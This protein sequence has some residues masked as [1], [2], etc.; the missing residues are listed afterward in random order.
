MSDHG[1]HHHH[2]ADHHAEPKSKTSFRASFWFVIILVGLF[3]G[4]VNFVGV[5]GH[6]EGG[7]E[8]TEQH[9]GAMPHE[10]AGHESTPDHATSHE[11]EGK[12]AANVHLT[13]SSDASATKAANEPADTADHH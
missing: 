11:D 1:T 7:H 10:A 4:A 2:E 12:G 9:G 8:A 3:I 5:M 13:G 6:D